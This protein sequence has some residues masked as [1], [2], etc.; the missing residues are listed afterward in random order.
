MKKASESADILSGSKYRQAH[1]DL[2]PPNSDV[3]KYAPEWACAVVF[4][5]AINTSSGRCFES[6]YE[7]MGAT[8]LSLYFLVFA[9]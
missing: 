5:K 3:I 2:C 4:L 7:L 8:S 1:I 6:T 9:G